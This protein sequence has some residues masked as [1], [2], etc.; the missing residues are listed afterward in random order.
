M[1]KGGCCCDPR[2]PRT[3]DTYVRRRVNPETRERLFRRARGFVRGVRRAAERVPARE[4]R[5]GNL[6]RGVR[7]VRLEEGGAAVFATFRCGAVRVYKT[8]FGESM[9]VHSARGNAK[10]SAYSARV[11][12]SSR[13]A[14]WRATRGALTPALTVSLR[15][16]PGVSPEISRLS[17]RSR[18]RVTPAARR[19]ALLV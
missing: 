14:R 7:A 16:W 17:S 15:A 1:H 9:R 10:R 5:D 4:S 2:D 11:V 6:A 19:S 12:A 18:P 8:T 13:S 3:P